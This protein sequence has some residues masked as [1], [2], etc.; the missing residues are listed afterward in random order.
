MIYT[1]SNTA[2]ACPSEPLPCAL[3][4]VGDLERQAYAPRSEAPVNQ[5]RHNGKQGSLQIVYRWDGV[6]IYKVL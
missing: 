4:Y 2:F 1:V 5:T 6:T 3:F